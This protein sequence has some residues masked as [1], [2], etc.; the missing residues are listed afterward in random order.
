MMYVDDAPN[1]LDVPDVCN[2]IDVPDVTDVIEVT[3]IL[4]ITDVP[5]VTNVS[6]HLCDLRSTSD[7]SQV[8]TTG[9]VLKVQHNVDTEYDANDPVL[10][11]ISSPFPSRPPSKPLYPIQ[12]CHI[13]LNDMSAYDFVQAYV[14]E[15][16]TEVVPDDA[17][18][19]NPPVD[20]FNTVKGSFPTRLPPDNTC[21][22]LPKYSKCSSH[23]S[24][25]EYKV[26]FIRSFIM[27]H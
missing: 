10:L 2:V 20:E 11:S 22:E 17:T 8:T 16:E 9:E 5:D 24:H 3:G 18:T 21:Q 25:V 27:S 14:H 7:N 13:N 23:L 1:I 12:L 6:D 15:G 4:D 19:Y 26:S